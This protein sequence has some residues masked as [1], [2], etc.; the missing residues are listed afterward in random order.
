MIA[1]ETFWS[2]PDFVKLGHAIGIEDAVVVRAP[3][4]FKR[5]LEP[6]EGA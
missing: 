5:A 2:G 6:D 4:Y 3:Q 1:T